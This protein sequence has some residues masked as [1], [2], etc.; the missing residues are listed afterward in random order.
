[1]PPP[2]ATSATCR[3]RSRSMPRPPP[4][5]EF[6]PLWWSCS[7]T[8]SGRYSMVATPTS[9][10]GLS[11][12]SDGSRDP[13]PTSLAPPPQAVFGMSRLPAGSNVDGGLGPDPDHR[14]GAGGRPVCRGVLRLLDVHHESPR[15]PARPAGCLSHERHQPGRPHTV[16]HAHLVR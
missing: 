16:V 12:P 5:R 9:A 3:S 10:T 4:T 6:R 13:S 2:A 11:G 8:S 1:P 14:G 7:A 15:A